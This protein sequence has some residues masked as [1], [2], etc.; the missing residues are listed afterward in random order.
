MADPTLTNNSA[1]I[2]WIQG[3]SGLFRLDPLATVPIPAADLDK[4]NATL[5]GPFKFYVDIGELLLTAAP[6]DPPEALRA[7]PSKGVSKA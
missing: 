3:T 5:A 2:F 7:G 4:V 6:P 1:R